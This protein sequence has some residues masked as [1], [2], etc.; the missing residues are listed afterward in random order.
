MK[1][2]QVS[3]IKNLIQLIEDNIRGELDLDV[4]AE[5]I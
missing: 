5:E 1:M 3:M 4:I 2:D